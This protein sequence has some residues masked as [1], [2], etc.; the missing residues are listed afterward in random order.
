[1][2]ALPRASDMP[3]GM[4]EFSRRTLN[5][6]DGDPRGLTRAC[7]RQAEGGRNSVRAGSS[8]WPNSGSVDLCGRG[9]EGLQLMRKSLGAHPTKKVSLCAWLSRS[10]VE[11]RPSRSSLAGEPDVAF[12]AR[13]SVRRGR[14]TVGPNADG[15]ARERSRI[16]EAAAASVPYVAGYAAGGPD[17]VRGARRTEAP[18]GSEAGNR[19]AAPRAPGHVEL[20]CWGG[21]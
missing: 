7:S 13:T 2:L 12:A 6:R 8:Q 17:P 1:M 4:Y 3:R 5:L 9:L 18:L 21:A 10:L 14:T 16:G 11:R 20:R 19:A 15:R